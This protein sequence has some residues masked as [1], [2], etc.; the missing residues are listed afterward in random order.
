MD[1]HHGVIEK[2]MWRS[3][4]FFKFSELEFQLVRSQ[5]MDLHQE[6]IEKTHVEEC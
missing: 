4:N 5:V 1:L 3:A 2:L 6:V